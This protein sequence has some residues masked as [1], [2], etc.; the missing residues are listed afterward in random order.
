[1]GAG[2]Q[3]AV[4]N[5]TE[6]VAALQHQAAALDRA[7]KDAQRAAAA[8]AESLERLREAVMG[9]E[10]SASAGEAGDAA[11]AW[12]RWRGRAEAL[13]LVL[14]VALVVRHWPPRLSAATDVLVAAARRSLRGVSWHFS[15]YTA[16]PPGLSSSSRRDNPPAAA[17]LLGLSG[18][19]LRDGGGGGGGVSP[20]LSSLPFSPCAGPALRGPGL[21]AA[22]CE[23]EHVGCSAEPPPWPAATPNAAAAGGKR[24][25]R[26]PAGGASAREW[27]C[28]SL[29]SGAGGPGG[30]AISRTQS[31]PCPPRQLG[32][33]SSCGAG[34]GCGGRS[35]AVARSASAAAA[36]HA[37][38]GPSTWAGCEGM[39]R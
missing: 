38:S 39:E 20:M 5:L 30:P 17:G 23:G 36:Q 37:D 11:G 8:Q 33:E 4:S 19:M 29:G 14:A 26:S 32:P 22:R 27:S 2:A 1:M 10:G 3:L 16:L 13:A 18:R 15:R 9:A 31:Y 6:R 35:A 34:G 24:K 12:A 21:H 25:P 7:H 28:S